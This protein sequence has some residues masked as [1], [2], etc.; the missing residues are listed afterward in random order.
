MPRKKGAA[1]VNLTEAQRN[2]LLEGFSIEGHDAL[3]F[4]TVGS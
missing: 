4:D 2:A 3:Q 1:V